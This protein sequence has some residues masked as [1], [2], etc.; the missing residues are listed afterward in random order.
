MLHN[1]ED[2]K[3]LENLSNMVE[4]IRESHQRHARNISSVSEISTTGSSSDPLKPDE[5]AEIRVVI[6]CDSEIEKKCVREAFNSLICD[7]Q[8]NIK[9]AKYSRHRWDSNEECTGMPSC[10]FCIREPET[11]TFRHQN[12]DSGLRSVST[13]PSNF[14]DGFFR[15]TMDDTVYRKFFWKVLTEARNAESISNFRKKLR[16]LVYKE[17]SPK[18][19]SI[20]RIISYELCHKNVKILIRNFEIFCQKFVK[21]LMFT[22]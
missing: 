10:F 12:S 20:W 19:P 21:V 4:K 15:F 16:K 7:D 14:G 8:S 22:F 11:M 6:L 3:D 9:D 2:V 5:N 17:N 18:L 1:E 13:A